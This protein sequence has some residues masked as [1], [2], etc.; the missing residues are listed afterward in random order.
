M[1]FITHTTTKESLKKENQCFSGSGG[2]SQKNKGFGFV[3]AFLDIASGRIYR[4]CFADGTPA[5]IHILDG[6]PEE[7]IIKRDEH[8]TFVSTSHNIISGFE[9]EGCFYTRQQVADFI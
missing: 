2:V 7:T 3:P 9:R 4:S 6:L 8:G 1:N 5:P